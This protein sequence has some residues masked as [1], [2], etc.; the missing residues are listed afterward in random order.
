MAKMDGRQSEVVEVVQAVPDCAMKGVCPLPIIKVAA[1]RSMGQHE[2]PSL[3]KD[4]KYPDAFIPGGANFPNFARAP[5][6]R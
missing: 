3:N 2:R 4:T 6:I 5:V 1:P